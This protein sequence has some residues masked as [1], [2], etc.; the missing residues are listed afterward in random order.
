M[1]EPWLRR[2][3]TG[4]WRLP[5]LPPAWWPRVLIWLIVGEI[6]LA[7]GTSLP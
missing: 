1:A 3:Y 6:A 2:D 7:I 4:W 5:T